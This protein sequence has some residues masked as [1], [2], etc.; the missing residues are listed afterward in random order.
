MKSN[1]SIQVSLKI[2]LLLEEFS[3]SEIKNGIKLIER[4]TDND[5]PLIVFLKKV[6][7]RKS[8]NK[9]ATNLKKR[10]PLCSKVILDLEKT[11]KEKFLLLSKVDKS[12]R[13]GKVLKTLP[14]I[15][16]FASQISKKF[17][18]V[19]SRKEA[20]PKLMGLLA[21]MSINEATKVIEMIM[22]SQQS[23]ISESEYQELAKFLIGDDKINNNNFLE[24]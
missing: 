21:D 15:K 23:D 4:N 7:T 1:K 14:S 18:S 20:I 8:S 19:K 24:E 22:E 9:K 16:K 5:N 2:L 3:D 11:D 13:E 17:P 12:I 10:E 6:T